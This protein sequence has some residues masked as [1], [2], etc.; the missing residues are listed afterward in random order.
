MF[1]DCVEHVIVGQTYAT[2]LGVLSWASLDMFFRS[3]VVQAMKYNELVFN[4][5]SLRIEWR[6]QWSVLDDNSTI[7]I[8]P[9]HSIPTAILPVRQ[10]AFQER[11]LKSDAKPGRF[12]MDKY[13]PD[14]KSCFF[15][16]HAIQRADES[17]SDYEFRI[18][19]LCREIFAAI[20]YYSA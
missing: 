1:E 10:A 16:K 2:P 9:I 6:D 8:V 20:K 13:N 17:K 18:I 4:N 3:L 12:R 15:D 19:N 11:L 7:K 5:S 14:A